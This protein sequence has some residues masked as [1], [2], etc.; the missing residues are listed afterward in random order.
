MLNVEVLRSLQVDPASGRRHLS[1][2]SGMV[3]VGRR[4]YV[5]ADDENQL[6]VFDLD[7]DRPGTLVRLFDGEL[8]AAPKARKDAKPDF[9]SLVLLPPFR[10]HP[11]GALLALGSGSRVQRHRAAL[12]RL[13]GAGAL[14]DEVRE[15]DLSDLYAPLHE[16]Y[17][18]LNIEG[19]FVEAERFCLLQRGNASEPANVCITFE[20]PAIEGWLRGAGAVPKAVSHTRYELSDVDGVP[21]CFTDGAPLPGGGW[22]FCAAAEAT[23]DNYADGPCR[24]SAVGFVGADGQLGTMLPLSLRCKAE[25][26]TASVEDGMLRL[27][28]V[29]DADDPAAPA[30]LLSATVALPGV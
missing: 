9:E 27:L 1:A 12:L 3:R 8:P 21:L 25:G 20:W 7:G 26:I 5:V 22:M 15:I 28:L 29:T 2:A 18:L 4:L 23:A 13:D 14:H 30:L 10:D 16:R 6:G 24:G 17:A 11:H 19:G